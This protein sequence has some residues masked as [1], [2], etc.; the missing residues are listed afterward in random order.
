MKQKNKGTGKKGEGHPVKWDVSK[1]YPTNTELEEDL[2]I[3]TTPKKLLA[4]VINYNPN[5]KR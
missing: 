4:A 1:H 2:T 3:N 5:K